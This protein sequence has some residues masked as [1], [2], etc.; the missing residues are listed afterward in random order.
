MR[1]T[2]PQ[3]E[4]GNDKQ[5]FAISADGEPSRANQGHFIEVDL[6]LQPI[7]PPE[8]LYHG[9][10]AKFLDSIRA[11]GLVRGSRVH[12]TN[13]TLR[14]RVHVHQRAGNGL[15]ACEPRESGLC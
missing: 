4:F 5:R 7:Q 9:T 3:P 6:G 10:V 14:R 11:S 15:A 12:R 8:L 2:E 13:L 1:G